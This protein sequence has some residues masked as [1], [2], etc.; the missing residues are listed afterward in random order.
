MSQLP[1]PRGGPTRPTCPPVLTREQIGAGAQRPDGARPQAP[2][3]RCAGRGGRRG[4]AQ[5]TGRGPHA[6]RRAQRHVRRSAGGRREASLPP[7]RRGRLGAGAG[8]LGPRA[9]V[10]PQAGRGLIRLHS[11]LEGVRS[12]KGLNSRGQRVPGA[13]PTREGWGCGLGVAS[14]E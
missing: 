7:R 3:P 6:P 12:Q 1:T 13:G 5:A 14:G 10:G 8:R 2:E 4:G 11:T 9:G